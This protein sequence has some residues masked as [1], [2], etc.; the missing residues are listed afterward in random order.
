MLGG[1]NMDLALAHLVESRLPAGV[2]ACRRRV[3]RS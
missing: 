1:D 3:F 2:A